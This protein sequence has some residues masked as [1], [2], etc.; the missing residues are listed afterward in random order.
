VI[1][2][3]GNKLAEDLFFDRQSTETKLLPPQLRRSAR[4]KML[5]LHDVPVL[6]DLRIPRGYRT[7]ALK[8]NQW[9]ITFRWDRDGAHEVAVIDFR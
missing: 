2:S 7:E 5:Y 9:R 3:F 4:R 6:S 1:E 8:N